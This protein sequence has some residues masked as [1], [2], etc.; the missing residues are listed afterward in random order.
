MWPSLYCAEAPSELVQSE[1]PQSCEPTTIRPAWSQG[2]WLRGSGGGVWGE[3][4]ALLFCH[5]FDRWAAA[6]MVAGSLCGGDLGLW[7]VDPRHSEEIPPGMELLQGDQRGQ[8]PPP[9]L[10]V[11]DLDM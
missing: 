9:A 11:Q 7:G 6:L 1:A 4:G 3:S 8:L 2:P 5:C 10:S